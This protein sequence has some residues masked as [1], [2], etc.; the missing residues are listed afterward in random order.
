MTPVP[1]RLAIR[2]VASL[3]PLAARWS[4][5]LAA[6][7]AGRREGADRL[8]RWSAEHRDPARPLL[9]VHGASAG[10]LRQVEPV[11][12]RLRA[13]HPGWQVAVTCFSPSGLLVAAALGADQSGLL[14]W[15]TPRDVSALLDQLRPTAIVLSRAE[16]WPELLDSAA[17]RGIRL[18]LLAAT[19][20]PWSR[21]LRWPA[22]PLLTRALQSLD[23]VGAI[24]ADDAARL[25]ALGA[26]DEALVVTGDPRADAVLERLERGPAP[27]P[28]PCT[29]VAGSTWPEDEAVL[30]TAFR[31]VRELHPAARLLLVPHEPTPGHLAGLRARARAAGLGEV[32]AFGPADAAAPVRVVESV[33]G[34]ALLYGLGRIAYVGG[35]LGG[36]GLHSVLEPAAAGV[37]IVVGAEG[38]RSPDAVRLNE[39]GALEWLPR[40]RTAA[41]LEAWWATWLTDP[42]WC[43]RAGASARE[44]VATGRGA[45][46]RSAALV[47]RLMGDTT[48]GGPE[49]R[50]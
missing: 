4:P 3:A 17:A 24:T 13:R 46:D 18:G 8:A 20:P 12:L 21:R 41:V 49:A 32:P 28:E 43:R 33:G 19:I 23:A 40:R 6:G 37:P 1:Y 14:P 34:L 9:L 22:R 15:D 27:R 7:L 31:S 42:E 48:G 30:L 2:A 35:G 11:V 44:C 50:H 47:E 45:A 36:A 39:V 25:R 5:K 16:L 10:E 26:R 29:L 38:R